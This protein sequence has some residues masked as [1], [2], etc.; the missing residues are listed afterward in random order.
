MCNDNDELTALIDRIAARIGGKSVWSVHLPQDTHIPERAVMPHRRSIICR[1]HAGGMA[2]ARGER[3]AAAPLRPVRKAEPIQG[4]VCHRPDGRRIIFTW[5]RAT[6]AVVR[7]EGPE[8]IAMEWW[9]QAAR[10]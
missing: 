10:P 7:V 6:H 8:R 5:R 2:G 3:A 1:G 4:A 9:K